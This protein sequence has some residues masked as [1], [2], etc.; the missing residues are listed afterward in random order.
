MW[1]SSSGGHHVLWLCHQ[2]ICMHGTQE[3]HSQTE[4]QVLLWSHNPNEKPSYLYLEEPGS[5]DSS[6][7]GSCNRTRARVEL[8]LGESRSYHIPVLGSI[9]VL[10]TALFPPTRKTEPDCGHLLLISLSLHL[11][12]LSS[13]SSYNFKYYTE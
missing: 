3:Q 1:V 7:E 11:P 12:Q 2:W 4:G 10:P 5:Q 13:C 9:A 8:G 6:E